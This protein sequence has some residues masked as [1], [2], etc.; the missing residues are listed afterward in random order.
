[1]T[2]AK[3]DQ[4]GKYWN[5]T[6]TSAKAIKILSSNREATTKMVMITGISVT[7]KKPSSRGLAIKPYRALLSNHIRLRIDGFCRVLRGAKPSPSESRGTDTLAETFWL[8]LSF[9]TKTSIIQWLIIVRRISICEYEYK[10]LMS[11]TSSIVIGSVGVGCLVSP[12]HPTT[13]HTK[14]A[15]GRVK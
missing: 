5:R 2:W 14:A 9:S 10:A 1:M 15:H 11:T 7:T 8:I 12:F 4:P 3:R 13:R 6:L